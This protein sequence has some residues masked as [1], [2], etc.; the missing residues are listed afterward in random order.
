[1]TTYTKLRDGNWG[2]RGKNLSAGQTVSVTKRD[3]ARKTETV[4]KVLWR[5]NDG[6]CLA[7]IASTS[8]AHSGHSHG[9]SRRGGRYECGECGEFVTPGTQCWETGMMH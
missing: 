4:G 8:H 3:G 2:L 1:M 5:G 7:T 6:T 9:S